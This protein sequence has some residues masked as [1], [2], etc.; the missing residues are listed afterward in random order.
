MLWDRAEMTVCVV[1]AD[2]QFAGRG[3]WGRSWWSQPGNLLLSVTVEKARLAK[4]ISVDQLP[5]Q[6]AKVVVEWLNSQG[7]QTSIRGINDVILQD[8]PSRQSLALNTA[9][10]RA[11]SGK[12]CG[13]LV[14][15]WEGRRGPAIT[16]GMGLNCKSAPCWSEVQQASTS[17]YD[18]GIDSDAPQVAAALLPLLLA[19]FG[20]KVSVPIRPQLVEIEGLV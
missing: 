8:G 14:E 3:T 6:A 1:T 20:L 16:L 2:S 4:Q 5:L 10:P 12:V 13:L 11:G 7:A 15:T 17:L 19:L 18:H 9:A